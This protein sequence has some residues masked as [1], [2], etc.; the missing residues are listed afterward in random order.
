MS[1]GAEHPAALAGAAAAARAAGDDGASAELLDRADELDRERPGYYGAAVT[2]LA[3]VALDTNG[4]G[5][6]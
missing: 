2:A 3:R 6:C 5:S 1:G 4:L